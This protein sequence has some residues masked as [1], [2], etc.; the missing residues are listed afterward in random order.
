MLNRYQRI[1]DFGKDE[2]K[3]EVPLK[4]RQTVAVKAGDDDA[5]P[6]YDES[7]LSVLCDINM[8]Q[9]KAYTTRPGMFKMSVVNNE[10]SR[11][12]VL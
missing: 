11:A 10:K 6:P 3:K 4:R 9:E 8:T 7:T 5:V 12:T 1:R 2:P